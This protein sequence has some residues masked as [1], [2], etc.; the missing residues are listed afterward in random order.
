[1]SLIDYLD[2]SSQILFLKSIFGTLLTKFLSEI[3]NI[4]NETARTI[5]VTQNEL[6]S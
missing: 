4:E 5:L 1:M 2:Y 6:L 3:S